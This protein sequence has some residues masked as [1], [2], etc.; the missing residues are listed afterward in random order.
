MKC[1][2]LFCFIV[3]YVVHFVG[4]KNMESSY[5]VGTP[6]T[7]VSQSTNMWFKANRYTLN[8]DKQF[9]VVR[10]FRASIK[11]GSYLYIYIYVLIFILSQPVG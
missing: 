7:T 11:V 4:F 3:F 5:M 6:T 8:S 9:L 1:V 10:A 2:L